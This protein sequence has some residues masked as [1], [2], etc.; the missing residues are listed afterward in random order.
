[1][2]YIN[3]KYVHFLL[4]SHYPLGVKHLV[5]EL[6]ALL[7]ELDRH[8]DPMPK[9][10]LR[11]NLFGRRKRDTSE[12]A[13]VDVD[14]RM[15]VDNSTRKFSLN[16]L[17]YRKNTEF[18]REESEKRVVVHIINK[19]SE[20]TT[21]VIHIP[22]Q[23]IMKG[24]GD[25]TDGYQCYGHAITMLNTFGIPKDK[26]LVYCGITSRDWLTRMHEHFREINSGSN[27]LFHRQWR[28]YQGDASVLL[29]S[30]LIAV[31]HSY[32]G[33]MAWEEW[34][35]DKYMTEGCSLNMISGG[36][37]GLKELH[38]LGYLSRVE[39]VSQL[40]REEALE[41][42]VL[43]HPRSGVPNLLV[44]KLWLDDDYYTKVIGNRDNTFSQDEVH[45]IRKLFERGLS[46]REILDT[47]KVG[48]IQ[49]IKNVIEGKTYGRM[50]I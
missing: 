40:E 39:S 20:K 35:V 49:R 30:E 37:K 3:E 46:A 15:D 10:L 18:S 38:K 8:G 17:D 26:E 5:K 21:W 44:G 12:F 22:L 13:K 27:K 33:A 45:Q 42:Y 19:H 47:L 11:H 48:N 43:D 2:D 50:K 9:Q 7:D 23:A 1:M 31:N 41:K 29:N 14:I 4:G 6:E 25:P 32:E 16:L 28:E 34:A 24:F 36:F